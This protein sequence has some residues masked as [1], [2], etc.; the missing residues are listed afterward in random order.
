M[1]AVCV[2]RLTDTMIMVSVRD[3]PFSRDWSLPNNNMFVT[4]SDTLNSGTAV[5]TAVGGVAV[6][7]LSGVPKLGSVFEDCGLLVGEG[8]GD[9]VSVGTGVRVGVLLG[10]ALGPGVDVKVKV[11]TGVYVAAGVLVIVSVAEETAA[12]WRPMPSPA[13]PAGSLAHA[14]SNNNVTTPNSTTM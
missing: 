8:V 12:N 9:G 1:E 7:R 13:L 14:A 6:I 11:G 2:S 5:G 4:L 10:V 3:T